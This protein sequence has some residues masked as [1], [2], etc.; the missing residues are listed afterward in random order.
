MDADV[1]QAG[2]SARVA[3]LVVERAAEGSREAFTELVEIYHHDLLRLS[4]VVTGDQDLARD[5]TQAAWGHAWRKLGQL[6]DPGRIRP[7]LLSIAA[8]EA[9]QALR[10]RRRLTTDQGGLFEPAAEVDQIAHIDLSRALAR[11]TPEERRL[12]GL[13][14]VSGYSS[15]ELAQQLNVSPEAVR[16]RLKRIIDRLRRELSDG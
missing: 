11:L 13:R 6:R 5:A 14:Y 16:S 1:R 12:L 15:V 10:R 8:N 2:E 3:A 9:R 7:W 4:Y